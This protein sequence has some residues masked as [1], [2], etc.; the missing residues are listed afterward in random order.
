M[1]CRLPRSMVWI[2]IRWITIADA[3]EAYRTTLHSKADI[4]ST[5]V[6]NSPVS[7]HHTCTNKCNIL[8]IQ[9][10]VFSSSYQYRNI[11]GITTEQHTNSAKQNSTKHDYQYGPKERLKTA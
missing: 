8:T 6:Y 3:D 2:L 10:N 4:G 1:V 11:L 5:V 9:I 7:I